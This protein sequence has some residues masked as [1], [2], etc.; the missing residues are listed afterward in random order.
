MQT[1]RSKRWRFA[2]KL[3]YAT[4]AISN[5][6]TQTH[7]HTLVCLQLGCGEMASLG[8]EKIMVER[9]RRLVAAFAVNHNVATGRITVLGC[10]AD[11]LVR[12]VAK[13][14]VDIGVD[15]CQTAAGNVKS[16]G[17]DF[18]ATVGAAKSARSR[19]RRRL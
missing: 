2:T 14:S 11:A 16:V 19:I 6:L 9:A 10:P 5:D 1:G 4:V 15:V 8:N 7:Q 13:T 18:G 3:F 12:T 17:H